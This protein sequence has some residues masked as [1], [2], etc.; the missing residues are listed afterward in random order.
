MSNASPVVLRPYRYWQP[1]WSFWLLVLLTFF[2]SFFLN[3]HLPLLNWDEGAFASASWQMLN[4]GNYLTPQ[5]FGEARF[6]KPI[7]I[8]YLQAAALAWVN[9]PWAVRLPSL[10][11]GFFWALALAVF[12]QREFAPSTEKNSQ[13]SSQKTP[14]KNAGKIAFLLI[15]LTLGSSVITHAATADAWLNFFLTVS[16][17]QLYR[18]WQEPKNS[19]AWW[20]FLSVALGLL[21]KGPIA[22]AIPGAVSLFFYLLTGQGGRWLKLLIFWPGWLLGLLVV[23][24]WYGLIYLEHGQAFIEGFFGR[25]HLDRLTQPLENHGGD[26]WYY[27][28][29]VWLLVLPFSFWLFFA[30][31]RLPR[32]FKEKAPL[33]LFLTLWF[34]LVFILFT[35]TSTKLPH[36]LLYASVPLFLLLVATPPRSAL[37]TLFAVMP[38]AIFLVL[39]LFLP[40]FIRVHLNAVTD[41]LLLAQLHGLLQSFDASYFWSVGGALAV[42]LLLCWW[43]LPLWQKPLWAALIFLG[44]FYGQ[45]LP[46]YAEIVEKPIEDIGMQAQEAQ[47]TVYLYRLQSPSLTLYQAHPAEKLPENPPAGAWLATTIKHRDA[48]PLAKVLYQQHGVV[49]LRL[50]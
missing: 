27:F 10:L 42:M 4:S 47:K 43:P 38:V 30:L 19:T 32:L 21:M 15:P 49:L 45:L 33:F 39:L 14:G 34:V 26:V 6:D 18:Y 24:P 12:A 11:A 28:I 13:K 41:I 40:E 8:Y 46:K 29:A 2:V 3:I 31:W 50:P 37:M 7:S 22:V 25:H 16:M 35:L 23:L 48:F 5:L 20:I 36:Y 9:E 1:D 17:L 44:I